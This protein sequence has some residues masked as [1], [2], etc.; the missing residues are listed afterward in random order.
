MERDTERVVWLIALAAGM[1]FATMMGMGFFA[2]ETT[3]QHW[4]QTVLAG[5]VVWFGMSLAFGI[6]LFFGAV[7]WLVGHEEYETE[8]LRGGT[9]REALKSGA[10]AAGVVLGVLILMGW[11]GGGAPPGYY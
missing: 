4:W 9:K 3:T 6:F 8:R 10:I 5:V 7:V 1:G 2:E 11:C